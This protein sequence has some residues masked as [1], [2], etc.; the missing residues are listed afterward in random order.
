MGG[1]RHSHSRRR[2][3]VSFNAPP[4]SG[5]ETGFYLELG[6]TDYWIVDPERF[7]IRSVRQGR[8]D[9]VCADTLTWHPDGASIPLVLS[10]PEIFR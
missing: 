10:V 6:I 3:A 1:G 9:A 5:T 2:G 8:P 7:E 4:R